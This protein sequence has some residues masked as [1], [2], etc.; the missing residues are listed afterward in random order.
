IRNNIFSIL[1]S[2]IILYLSM[3]NAKTF[4]NAGLFDIP[5]LDK[6]V[7]FG[8][9]FV[10]MS[11]IIYEHRNFFSDTRKIILVAL[12]PICFGIIIELMQSGFTSTR[13]GDVIDAM[14][15]TGGVAASVFLWLFIRPYKSK[16]LK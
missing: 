9:Y 10:F 4:E 11:V 12:V 6:F 2:L 16:N 8:L 15:N 5:Y 1:T 7:H 3:A 13:K 14:F